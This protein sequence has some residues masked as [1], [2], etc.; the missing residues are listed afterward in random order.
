M[1]SIPMKSWR[2]FDGPGYSQ[3]WYMF[4]GQL[5]I[6]CILLLVGRVFYKCWRDPVDWWCY[7]IFFYLGHSNWRFVSFVDLFI[8]TNLDFVSLLHFFFAIHYFIYLW[9]KLNY[10]LSSDFFKFS[11]LFFQVLI[12][13]PFF[14]YRQTLT[15]F[16]FCP[17]I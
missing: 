10:F 15:T 12:L 13:Y 16:H 5:E 17:I 8:E 1:I 11:L 9:C 3:N 2:L 6:M 14:K 4:H 7:S